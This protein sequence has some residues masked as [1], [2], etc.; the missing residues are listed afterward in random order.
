MRRCGSPLV[1]RMLGWRASSKRLHRDAHID[2]CLIEQILKQPPHKLSRRIADDPGPSR[3]L[4]RPHN[5]TPCLDVAKIRLAN[6]QFRRELPLVHLIAHP[7][8]RNQITERKEVAEL[9]I[10]PR[11]YGQDS[12]ALFFFR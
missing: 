3:R 7:K 5:H 9:T 4:R 6:A 1:K 11:R 8:R 2:L 10:N 12:T